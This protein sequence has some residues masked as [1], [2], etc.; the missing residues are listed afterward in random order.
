[1]P[2][3][4]FLKT[5]IFLC[6]FLFL[7]VL[8]INAKDLSIN[9]Q[10]RDKEV[11]VIDADGN[12]LGIMDA[13]KANAIADAQNLDLVK[14][15][16]KAQPPVCKI[17]DF[18]KYCYDQTKKEKEARKNQNIVTV[19]EIQLTLKINTHDINTKAGH[20]IR[21]LKNGDKVKV[22]VKYKGREMA[23]TEL[24]EAIARR[25]FALTEEVAVIEKPAKLEGRNL[26]MILA[27][28]PATKEKK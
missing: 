19:K 1:M 14:I 12:Q 27:P 5:D 22:V 21:F 4:C 15:A 18:H 28:K 24:G 20:A 7:E 25:F 6:P 23:H 9:E 16:P 26:I 2:Y 11:R 17:M 13:A 8:S 3:G 10:I